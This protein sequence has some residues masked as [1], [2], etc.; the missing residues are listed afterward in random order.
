[1]Y[2]VS[3]LGR[4][5]VF[6]FGTLL[7]SSF[8][9]FIIASVPSACS[10][11]DCQW[12]PSQAA[13]SD[14]RIHGADG[15]TQSDGGMGSFWRDY[16]EWIGLAPSSNAEYQGLLQGSLGYSSLKQVSVNDILHKSFLL[17]LLAKIIM[18]VVLTYGVSFPLSALFVVFSHFTKEYASV[19]IGLFLLA[20][21]NGSLVLGVMY[22]GKYLVTASPVSLGGGWQGLSFSQDSLLV[23]AIVSWLPQLLISSAFIIYMTWRTY[24]I[25]MQE[26]DKVYITTAFIRG[27]SSLTLLIK[28]PFR[29]II[30]RSVKEFGGIIPQIISCI[31]VMALILPVTWGD[32]I[33]IDAIYGRDYQ[34]LG[35]LLFL[36]V[37]LT[38]MIKFF[39]ELLS[40]IVGYVIQGFSERDVRV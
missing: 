25:W 11:D 9:G 36:I 1:M 20:V 37:I 19:V 26:M 2:M 5:V 7:L 30:L 35:A 28:Y 29:T 17:Y 27:L 8:I 32:Q 12:Q 23:V 39:F 21:L 16:A 13:I 15:Q 31:I 6:L 18:I 34:L 10:G 24:K 22:V 40:L 4:W 14:D 3:F 33:F 38:V